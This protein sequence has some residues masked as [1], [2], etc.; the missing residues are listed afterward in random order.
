MCDSPAALL[1]DERDEDD[2]PLGVRGAPGA[3]DPI[4]LAEGALGRA[5]DDAD[6][7]GADGDGLVVLEDAAQRG[8]GLPG[9]EGARPPPALQVERD[10]RRGEEGCDAAGIAPLQPL[11]SRIDA[12]DDV[13]ALTEAFGNAAV[14]GT[15]APVSIGLSIDRKNP[16]RYLATANVGGLGLPDKDFYANPDARAAWREILQ[17]LA[18]GMRNE[19]IATKLFISP[20]TV[21][22][23]VRNI[24]GKLRVHSKLEAVA[25]AVKH[26]AIVV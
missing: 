5:A 17:L 21:Q 18:E 2:A 4:E 14:D 24:L 22:T 16:D 19:G 23:H 3:H 12:I 6:H 26:G 13:A 8:G 15:A 25:F 20:Q 11:L 1:T 10:A 9:A 7:A